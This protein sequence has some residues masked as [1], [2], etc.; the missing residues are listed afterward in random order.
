[1]ANTLPRLLHSPSATLIYCDN[2]STRFFINGPYILLLIVTLSV[3]IFFK[4]HCSFIP[5]RPMIN[6]QISS[7]SDEGSFPATTRVFAKI[8]FLMILT[9]DG[10]TLSD[11]GKLI[12]R[13]KKSSCMKFG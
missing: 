11:V 8:S 12:Q 6:L 10:S 1:V 4:A 5:L 2:M 13:P 3:I 9:S 7:Q